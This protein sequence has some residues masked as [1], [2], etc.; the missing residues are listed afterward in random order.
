MADPKKD[1]E[2]IEELLSQLQ[3]IFGKLS[4]SEEEEANQ[5]VDLPRPRSIPITPLAR[6]DTAVESVSI[7]TPEPAAMPSSSPPPKPES[8][9]SHASVRL[10]PPA[11]PAVYDDSI[12]TTAIF[13]AAGRDNEAQVLKQKVEALT[14]KFT[15][16]SFKLKVIW[17]MPYEA[18]SEWKEGAMQRLQESKIHVF[19]LLNDRAM[20]E[21]KRRLIQT[22]TESLKI[23]FQEVTLPSLE[24]K[25]F[26]TD[27]LLGLVFFFD[28][29]KTKNTG[30]TPS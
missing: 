20:E 5:K 11:E 6:I 8:E 28:S 24:K 21:A 30:D 3:G 22:D 26:F 23:Y 19:F 1:D 14:P 10:E 25:A 2:H 7:P 13:Y 18:K 29:L 12:L 16:V 15:K 17:M 4:K 9:P 27:L